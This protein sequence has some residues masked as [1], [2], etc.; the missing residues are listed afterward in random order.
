MASNEYQRMLFDKIP[1]TQ[2]LGLEIDSITDHQVQLKAPLQ[3]N[4]NY[5]GTAFGGSLNTVAVLTCY[6]TLH[7]FLKTQQLHFSSLVIQS[8]Q[9]D[10]LLPT[11]Q[12][13]LST[14]QL[15]KEKIEKFTKLL[16]GKGL[17]RMSLEAKIRYPDCTK[18]RVHFQGQFVVSQSQ[19]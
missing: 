14:C 7:H 2:S 6:L 18:T 1:I 4:I 5:E 16:E 19:K 17:A 3:K 11:A 12:D 8:S 15:P 10:Y 13:F 9:I